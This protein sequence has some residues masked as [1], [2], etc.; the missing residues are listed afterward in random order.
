MQIPLYQID[1]FTDRL[2]AGNPAA[3]CLLDH[4]LADATLL[5]IAAENNLSETAFLVRQ[6]EDYALRWFTPTVEV[7][8]CGHATLAS[9]HLILDRLEPGRGSVAF[10]TQKAGVLTVSRR[11]GWLSMDFPARPPK[12]T[13]HLPQLAEALG[14]EPF[15]VLK[16]RDLMAV[17]DSPEDVVQLTPDFAAIAALDCWAVIATAPG[18]DGIDFV[19]RFFAPGHGVPED[20]VTGSAHCTLVP[21][22]AKRLGKT[23]LLARQVSARGGTLHC[24]LA[25]DR[26]I[27]AGQAILYL[28]G[29]ITV[30]D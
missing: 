18:R 28:E 9:A 6:G 17:F 13:L 22:W 3:V 27:L 21:Y 19:S 5:S 12:P 1:A 16:A 20:P 23:D 8:L 24:Q 4:W 2:F 25:G 14:R 30:P 7:D 11:D 10:H 29:R 15:C 26:V